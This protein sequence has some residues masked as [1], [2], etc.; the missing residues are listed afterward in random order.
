[1]S[2]YLTYV[3]NL[4]R[5]I[6]WNNMVIIGDVLVANNNIFPYIDIRFY[7]G[8][9]DTI[10][11]KITEIV[12][13]LERNC[14]ESKRIVV[15]S[16]IDN[17]LYV[18]NE[19]PFF[20]IYISK[21]MYKS[22]ED[23][24][25]SQLVPSYALAYDGN[26]I[27]TS[28]KAKY[29]IDHKINKIDGKLNTKDLV[30]LI[31]HRKYGFQIEGNYYDIDYIN[32]KCC[33]YM[34]LF[35]SR[36]RLLSYVD[37]TLCND[38]TDR[39][40]FIDEVMNPNIKIIDKLKNPH[41]DIHAIES[42]DN[43]L[44]DISWV[45]KSNIVQDY[46][47]QMISNDLLKSIMYDKTMEI[48]SKNLYD[49]S[50]RSLLYISLLT[51]SIKCNIYLMDHIGD[52]LVDKH[53]Q[54]TYLHIICQE[55]N[56]DIFTL[57]DLDNIEPFLKEDSYGLT[58]YMNTII[59]NHMDMYKELTHNL[60][61]RVDIH[62]VFKIAIIMGRDKII[63]KLISSGFSANIYLDDKYPIHSSIE[64]GH[65]KVTEV[66]LKN[67]SSLHLK[68]KDNY[69][70]ADTYIKYLKN[71]ILDINDAKQLLKVF[72]K[73][74]KSNLHLLLPSLIICSHEWLVDDLVSK[75]T[76]HL[77]DIDNGTLLD[78]VQ[79]EIYLVQG[80]NKDSFYNDELSIKGDELRLNYLKYLKQVCV[81]NGGK[82]SV[83]D[84][85]SYS[86][87][88]KTCPLNFH[89]ISCHNKKCKCNIISA[90]Y[91]KM[92]ES[93]WNNSLESFK[94]IFFGNRLRLD[95]TSSRTHRT[96]IHICLDKDHMEILKFLID[97]LHETDD[98]FL[99][100]FLNKVFVSPD[101]NLISYA[102]MKKSKRCLVYLLDNKIDIIIK[103]VDKN[104]NSRL[105][106]KNTL[107]TNNVDIIKKVLP[108]INIDNIAHVSNSLID[109][110]C[111]DKFS[112]LLDC[113]ENGCLYSIFYILKKYMGTLNLDISTRDT[114][115][116]GNTC[117]HKI[118]TTSNSIDDDYYN[119]VKILCK[120]DPEL[121]NI[122]NNDGETPLF[123]ALRGDD[124]KLIELYISLGAKLDIINK[125][126]WY[127]IHECLKNKNNVTKQKIHLMARH[128]SSILEI[129][130]THEKFT[131]LIVASKYNILDYIQCLVEMKVGLTDRDIYGNT[132]I[133]YLMY[134]ASE[135]VKDVKLDHKENI[136]GLTPLDCLKCKI[137]K[138]LSSLELHTAAQSIKLYDRY[139]G[140]YF[141][142]KFNENDYIYNSV[143]L[144]EN[145]KNHIF[146]LFSES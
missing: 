132:Y 32:N 124:I 31:R 45:V 94:D 84:S 19:P 122:C 46:K 96:I 1:M 95:V 14:F 18:I 144:I 5:E 62:K 82:F 99:N 30:T 53:T 69:S 136:F 21:N 118:A 6:N 130:T 42:V 143:K 7:G 93:I 41:G 17:G 123:A 12:S 28:S 103:L 55:G 129:T 134:N 60:G 107:L 37:T 128:T 51:K 74:Q 76:D 112:L 101:D 89:F 111:L 70:A 20:S 90:L 110:Y 16:K 139:Y 38:V 142:R 15:F 108:R 25:N 127:P 50:G 54:S 75:C 4:F 117:L 64:Y 126:G 120:I 125:R 39:Y 114:D 65:I 146:G 24:L 8:D 43:I 61:G 9:E 79:R 138:D 47:I 40:T 59:F 113:C 105:I 119:I 97:T 135:Y 115:K 44:K 33:R 78:K 29:A 109:E 56:T 2:K 67:N 22:I 102:F 133:H 27:T 3:N 66:L 57:I 13:I 88:T 58:P 81:I 35:A 100:N 145:A 116:Y 104:L 140:L 137:K 121:V 52:Q 63:S 141:Q 10:N 91:L 11:T 48:T 92:Y 98:V 23:I 34:D 131:P 77:N 68:N 86:E 83:D 36:S 26:D 71:G 72:I 73:H 106:L 80:N 49:I 85:L 87:D